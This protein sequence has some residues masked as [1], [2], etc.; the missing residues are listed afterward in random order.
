MPCSCVFS[1]CEKVAN[2]KP[3]IE[4]E[5]KES[6]NKDG[7]A[8]PKSLKKKDI[9]Q[10]TLQPAFKDK[11]K[12]LD[13]NRNDEAQ[14]VYQ[15]EQEFGH[16]S[17]TGPFNAE[18][19]AWREY[20]NMMYYSSNYPL[21]LSATFGSSGGESSRSNS[22]RSSIFAPS[23]SPPAPAS[24]VIAPATTIV[25]ISRQQGTSTNWDD[26]EDDAEQITFDIFTLF[27]VALSFYFL[28]LFFGIGINI[29]NSKFHCQF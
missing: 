6:V 17:A 9:Q 22:R 14:S 20:R 12:D 10:D 27:D 19:D 5:W 7:D 4:P 15:S 18:D 1:G 3:G 25:T 23:P 11:Q 28:S 26:K 21:P 13:S 16:F 2:D 29:H 8:E 24:D